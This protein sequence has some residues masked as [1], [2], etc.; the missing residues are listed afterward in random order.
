MVSP[1]DD[2]SYRTRQHVPIASMLLSN[3]ALWL[4]LMLPSREGNKKEG[5]FREIDGGVGVGGGSRSG[6][7][8]NVRG[9]S[10]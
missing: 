2:S 4:E 7:K 8:E 1:E 6:G 3:V 9:E 5:V 10:E